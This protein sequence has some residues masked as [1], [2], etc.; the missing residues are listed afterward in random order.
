MNISNETHGELVKALAELRGI[1]MNMMEV[2][3]DNML[4]W[5]KNE[6][7][8]WHNFLNEH[9]EIEELKSLEKE[10]NDRFF[11]KYNVGIEPRK[12]NYLRIKTFEKLI[13]QFHIALH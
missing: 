6:M 2:S 8:D 3:E 1:V 4:S 13:Q 7:D 12:L 10:V 9:L 11:F 5:L